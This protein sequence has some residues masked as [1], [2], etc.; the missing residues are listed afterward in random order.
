MTKMW[1]TP[2]VTSAANT[3]SL[4][5][6][7]AS[8]NHIASKFV[9]TPYRAKRPTSNDARAANATRRAPGRRPRALECFW[10]AGCLQDS[11]PAKLESGDTNLT[12]Q[13]VR[14]KSPLS[15]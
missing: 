10:R 11:Q 15:R 1:F 2:P 9:A 5:G 4:S 6:K 14:L 8:P 12:R 7:R 3:S 13:A